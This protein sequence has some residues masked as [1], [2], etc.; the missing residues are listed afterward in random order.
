MEKIFKSIA[1]VPLKEV[2]VHEQTV[3]KWARHLAYYMADAGTQKNPIV[4]HKI[5]RKYIVLDGMHR[6]EAMKIMKCRDIMVYI[7]DY[8][9]DKIELHNWYAIAMGELNIEKF[10]KDLKGEY[11]FEKLEKEEDINILIKERKIFIGISD[12][13]DNR[14]V[15]FNRKNL[16]GDDYIDIATSLVEKVETAIDSME[17]R[18]IYVPDNTGEQ[19]FKISRGSILIYRPL[20]KKEEI[21]KRTLSGK[22]FPRKSTRHIIPGRPL[23]VDINITLL[24]ENI[25][26]KTKN[27]LLKAHLLWCFESNKMRFYPE[28]VY[29]FS[30]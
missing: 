3:K 11:E 16:Y 22:T 4:V 29:I 28:P 1:I 20:F 13:K 14:Y 6:V 19:D 9:D 18:L 21:I 26:I 25:D 30:D 15:V 24:K 7:V 17:Y 23:R 2:L 10:L 5:N 27:K 12:K 8:F